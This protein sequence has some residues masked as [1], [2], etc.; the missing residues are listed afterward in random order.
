MD[1]IDHDTNMYDA[2]NTPGHLKEDHG[3]LDPDISKAKLEALYREA[4]SILLQLS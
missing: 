3:T 4:A 1:Y 2:L